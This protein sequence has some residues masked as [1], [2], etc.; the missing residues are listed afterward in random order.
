M[1][2]DPYL[3]TRALN[4]H[5]PCYIV[6]YDPDMEFVRQLEV[7]SVSAVQVQSRSPFVSRYSRLRG[8]GF[9]C[10]FTF[11]FMRVLLKNKFV[12]C[13]YAVFHCK[14]GLSLLDRNI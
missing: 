10:E 11:C 7:F 4:D 14:I 8:Q 13:S 9:Q 2:S 12:E 1:F 6:L 3:L 5:E